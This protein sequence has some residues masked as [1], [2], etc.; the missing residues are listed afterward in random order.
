MHRLTLR[1]AP[2]ITDAG[3]SECP[4]AGRTACIAGPRATAQ[5]ARN[6]NRSSRIDKEP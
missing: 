6:S 2:S 5:R 3:A 4:S 1:A